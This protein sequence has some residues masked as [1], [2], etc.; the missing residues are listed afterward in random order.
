MK[1]AREGLV[2]RFTPDDYAS[3]ATELSTLA[4]QIQQKYAPN[5][6]FVLQFEGLNYD[7][8]SQNWV[9]SQSSTQADQP[10]S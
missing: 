2:R 6:S 9:P 8:G 4:R 5:L 1:T 3:A 10:A 7:G